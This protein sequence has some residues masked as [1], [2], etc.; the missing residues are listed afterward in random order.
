MSWFTNGPYMQKYLILLASSVSDVSKFSNRH[1]LTLAL[2]AFC[3]SATLAREAYARQRELPVFKQ[4]FQQKFND[5]AR[6]NYNDVSVAEAS[7]RDP[8][9]RYTVANG[10]EIGGFV[11]PSGSIRDLNVTLRLSKTQ[12][13]RKFLNTVS[14]LIDVVDPSLGT[15]K[16]DLLNRLGISHRP[17]GELSRTE[18]EKNGF[19]YSAR[20]YD[21][22]QRIYFSV[23]QSFDAYRASVGGKRR[24]SGLA[25]SPNSNRTEQRG[26]DYDPFASTE[27]REDEVSSQQGT[28]E[29]GETVD[30]ELP[31]QDPIGDTKL[32]PVAPPRRRTQSSSISSVSS[33][34]RLAT[35][36][37]ENSP[38]LASVA[39][40]TERLILP[41][42]AADHKD[43]SEPTDFQVVDSKLTQPLYPQTSPSWKVLL[44]SSTI[45]ITLD[46]IIQ[47]SLIWNGESLFS[48][49]GRG[50]QIE[51]AFPPLVKKPFSPVSKDV[52]A[53]YQI[54]LRKLALGQRSSGSQ[55]EFLLQEA[56]NGL[57]L[58]HNAYPKWRLPL[59]WLG[60]CE[61]AQGKFSQARAHFIETLIIDPRWELPWHELGFILAKE[62]DKER[63]LGC[64][65]LA[66]GLSLDTADTMF[67][68]QNMRYGK[69]KNCA[70]VGAEA[71][72]RICAT[73]LT[74]LVRCAVSFTDSSYRPTD[75]VIEIV[76][77]RPGL[78]SPIREGSRF[79]RD[80][81]GLF[82]S[83]LSSWTKKTMEKT[84]K[85][86]TL[87]TKKRQ[88]V[89]ARIQI[90]RLGKTTDVE[91]V[92][93]TNDSLKDQQFVESIRR[94]SYDKLPPGAS[95]VIL[96][97]TF[98]LGQ[99]VPEELK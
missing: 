49:P 60:E 5:I 99:S 22:G 95:D 16:A 83:D 21:A 86:G 48:D 51:A 72:K 90:D 13:Y 30:S 55:R 38:N 14:C 7:F 53:L 84:T 93:S 73:E 66:Y 61:L 94:N 74:Y 33:G 58:A 29:K 50:N 91:L 70:E 11:Y 40:P 82:K 98:Y 4:N 47:A 89:S 92:Q 46:R 3:L 78:N 62:G 35:D 54:S 75:G 25:E 10:V 44:K 85:P 57:L 27:T 87:S 45:P 88:V 52:G 39:P 15:E 17:N 80:R 26:R 43:I 65:L 36:K 69:D 31:Q 56:A 71:M 20:S 23:S 41:T 28:F 42:K 59:C 63:S 9:C 79:Q 67:N 1:A 77:L 68:I 96:E 81:K 8:W 32:P 37:V 24:N 2:V 64:L 19:E 76:G 97:L 34:D 12:D 6:K 18:T